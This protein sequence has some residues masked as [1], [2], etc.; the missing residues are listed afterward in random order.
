MTHN[1]L[2][3]FIAEALAEKADCDKKQSN[4][5]PEPDPIKNNDDE[6]VIDQT[7]QSVCGAVAGVTTPLGT[8]PEY[9][10]KRK[11]VNHLLKNNKK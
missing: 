7:E 9:P 4:L 1:I 2:K 3:R 10:N 11:K 5:I 6:S 8:G